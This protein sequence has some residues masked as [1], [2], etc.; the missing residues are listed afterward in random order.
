MLQAFASA[1]SIGK[2]APGDELDLTKANWFNWKKKVHSEL[3]GNRF[4]GASWSILNSQDFVQTPFA[5]EPFINDLDFRFKPPILRY[6][7][8]CPLG[9]NPHE[10]SNAN[11]KLPLSPDGNAQLRADLETY[12]KE[13]IRQSDQDINCCQ[14]LMQRVSDASK[15]AIKADP[16][17]Q[18]WVQLDPNDCCSAYLYY[19]MLEDLH[20]IGNFSTALYRLNEFTSLK[21]GSGPHEDFAD[22]IKT[23][24]TSF[25]ADFGSK[26]PKHAGYASIENITLAIYINGVDPVMFHTKTD[27]VVKTASAKNNTFPD[28]HDTINDFQKY[29]AFKLISKPSQDAAYAA[30]TTTTA[31]KGPSAPRAA[32]TGEPCACCLSYGRTRAATSHPFANCE[33]NPNNK[34]GFKEDRFKQAEATRAQYNATHKSPS[35]AATKPT[36]ATVKSTN[37]ATANAATDPTSAYLAALA[38]MTPADRDEAMAILIEAEV[39][40]QD[41]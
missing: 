7:R 15:T 26:D 4:A 11:K 33:L 40:H 18:E 19:Q 10:N 35:R 13:R 39:A 37:K 22:R 29:N 8:A 31:T 30:Y 9:D 21:Q 28:L 1:Q 6:G 14:F 41:A 25:A 3:E 24:M 12:R 16:R 32:Y 23:G 27:D 2:F 38:Q 5:T 17:Y 20:A 36:L 34:A